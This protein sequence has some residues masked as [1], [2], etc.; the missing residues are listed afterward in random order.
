MGFFG[1]SNRRDAE[2]TVALVRERKTRRQHPAPKPIRQF[3]P[4]AGLYL[5]KTTSAWTKGTSRTLKHYTG[6]QGSETDSGAE[7]GSVY[8]RLADV[9]TDHWLYVGLVNGN[10]EVVGADPC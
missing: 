9:P 2:D 5:S 8:L 7:I 3:A 4:I 6:T 1:F 10:L